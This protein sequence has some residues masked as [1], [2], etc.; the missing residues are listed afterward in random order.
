MAT[1]TT[2]RYRFPPGF[3]WGAATSAYQIEGSPLADGAGVSI[4]HR[5]AHTP[6]NTV[7]GTTGD[8]LAD[9]YHRWAED[10]E[11]MR[12]LGLNAY[13]FSIAWPRV[14]PN[15]LGAVNQPGVDFYDRLVDAL[16]EAGVQSA[17]IL[18]ARDFP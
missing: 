10:I 13:Q 12:Q 8:V 14:L 9:H 1:T 15:G 17:P 16:L 7:D 3:V 5:Y 6:G 11:I 18:H 4:Q 2:P